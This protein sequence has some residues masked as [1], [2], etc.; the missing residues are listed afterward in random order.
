MDGDEEFG[1]E[2]GA[3]GEEESRAAQQEQSQDESFN[4]RPGKLCGALPNF[5]LYNVNKKSFNLDGQI[6]CC[7]TRNSC[8]VSTDL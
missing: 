1:M 8:F 4:S 5:V 6:S 3:P 2:E 7:T